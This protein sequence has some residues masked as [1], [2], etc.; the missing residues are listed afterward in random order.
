VSSKPLTQS[1]GNL[2]G[3]EGEHFAGGKTQESVD[4][5]CEYFIACLILIPG[6]ETLNNDN[7]ENG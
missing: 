1:W 4:E 7:T 2:L 6:C 5:N 3:E